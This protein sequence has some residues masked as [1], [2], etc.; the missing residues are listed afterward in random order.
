[1]TCVQDDVAFLFCCDPAI[2]PCAH[3]VFAA[4]RSDDVYEAGYDFDGFPVLERRRPSG[5]RNFL[6]RTRDV[7]S[8][9][10]DT[11]VP[12]LNE[13]LTQC[14]FVVV[15]NWHEGPNAPD[16]VLTVHSTGDVVS[17]VFALT[18]HSA[19]RALLRELDTQRAA[20]CGSDF[21]TWIEA[22]HWSGI[23][24]GGDPRL[25]D[26]FTK[27]VF[28]LE[29]GSSPSAWSDRRAVRA[30]ANVCLADLEF[31]E[32][33]GFVYFG[34]T[35]FESNATEA[36]LAGGFAPAHVLSNH[37]LVSG[38]YGTP[39]GAPKL[40]SCMASCS[41]ELDCLVIHKGLKGEVRAAV[42]DFAR[43]RNC[44]VVDHRAFRTRYKGISLRADERTR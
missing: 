27:P 21:A 32:G 9:D 43:V 30:V 16:R 31:D 23:P 35:H 6:I 12:M 33:P 36:V 29:I 8:H 40:E 19:F 41:G 22:T 4:L 10:Y 44:E 1:M 42:N 17:G 37:W 15:V 39:R 28:D 7:V 11:Y 24:K 14:R 5:G 20:L 26:Q 13:A 2:D 18:D 34:G 38:G 3:H 25:I